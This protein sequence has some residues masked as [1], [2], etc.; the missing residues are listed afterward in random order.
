MSVRPAIDALVDRAAHLQRMGVAI[1][2]RRR[3]AVHRQSCGSPA[4]WQRV[5]AWRP[6]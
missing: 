3:T 1:A 5:R 4:N 2:T 6:G